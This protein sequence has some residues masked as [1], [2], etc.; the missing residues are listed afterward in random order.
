MY[1]IMMYLKRLEYNIKMNVFIKNFS[2][3]YNR[4]IIHWPIPEQITDTTVKNALRIYKKYRKIHVLYI[5]LNILRFKR[6]LNP[7]TFI[8]TYTRKHKSK[9]K[10]F[11]LSLRVKKDENTKKKNCVTGERVAM[12]AGRNEVQSKFD[13]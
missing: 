9:F 5:F 7:F 3:I 11:F 12:I 2:I 13:L 10:P 4:I 8:H 6:A 1:N